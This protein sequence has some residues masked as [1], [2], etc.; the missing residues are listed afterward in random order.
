MQIVFFKKI[1]QTS[2]Y[3]Q[4]HDR[5]GHLFTMYSFTASWWQNNGK[6]REKYYTFKTRK[7]RDRTL[8]QILQKKQKDGYKILYHYFRDAKE[9]AVSSMI[10][11]MSI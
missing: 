1:N 4:I 3:Y 10:K 9:I 11:K 6:A 5:Q 7:E 8:R 2:Y